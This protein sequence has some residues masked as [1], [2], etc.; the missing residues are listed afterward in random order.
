MYLEAALEGDD[1]RVFLMALKDVA[2]AYGGLAKLAKTTGLNRENLYRMLSGGQPGTHESLPR[3][4]CARASPDCR[5]CGTVPRPDRPAAGVAQAD[6]RPAS[7]KQPKVTLSRE[8][9]LA[10]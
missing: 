6:D 1:P 9:R 5:T 7:H 3:A 2:E 8:Q 4:A 10:S